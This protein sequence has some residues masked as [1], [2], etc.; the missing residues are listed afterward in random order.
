MQKTSQPAVC[1]LLAIYFSSQLFV[2][3]LDDESWKIQ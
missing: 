1:L 2:I 3:L